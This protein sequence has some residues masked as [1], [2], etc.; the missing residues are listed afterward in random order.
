MKTLIALGAALALHGGHLDQTPT[1]QVWLWADYW[2][3]RATTQTVDAA[4]YPDNGQW[5][6]IPLQ[7]FTLV[8]QWQPNR[9]A[10]LPVTD[11][12]GTE[13]LSGDTD[14]PVTVCEPSGRVARVEVMR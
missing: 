4:S 14:H 5:D 11:R 10:T 1:K 6:I 8:C 9:W 2:A 7:G 12:C 13:P 3:C